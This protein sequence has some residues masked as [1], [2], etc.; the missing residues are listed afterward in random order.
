MPGEM[1]ESDRGSQLR[2]AITGVNGFIGCH[3]A[4]AARRLGMEVIGFDLPSSRRRGERL[5]ASLS[6]DPLEAVDLDLLSHEAIVRALGHFRPQ[7][8][9]HL[10]GVTGRS[11]DPVS[12]TRCVDG[13]VLTTAALLRA[14]GELP[15]GGSGVADRPVLVLPGSQMEY[16]RAPMPWTEDRP[17]EPI[18]P[19]AASKLCATE[20]LRAARRSRL[21]RGCV[22]RLPLVYGPGQAPTMLVPE[23]ITKGLG[24]RPVEMTSGTQRRRLTFVED[25]AEQLLTVGEWLVL[26]WQIPDLLNGRAR[27]PIAIMDLA[28]RIAALIPGCRL[29]PGALPQRA[30]EPP[31]SW[32]DDSRA[33]DLGLECRWDLEAGLSATVDWY[34][35]NEWFWTSDAAAGGRP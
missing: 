8:V 19:Y 1:P 28:Q 27:E 4:R 32:P 35:E 20:L 6:A 18:N 16:G 15:A 5:R 3:V 31:D 29:L 23:I 10:A 34:R 25:V 30:G 21:L 11:G 22:L 7:I 14:L 12:W 24:G 2:L 17:G 26:D 13:N 9:I 33:R